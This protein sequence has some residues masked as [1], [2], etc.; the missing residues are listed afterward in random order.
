[1]RFS[2]KNSALRAAAKRIDH[3]PA[4]FPSLSGPCQLCPDSKDPDFQKYPAVLS[5][6]K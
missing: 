6:H 3:H 2:P 1:M 4:F 5:F